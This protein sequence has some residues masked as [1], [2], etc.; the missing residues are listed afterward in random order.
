MRKSKRGSQECHTLQDDAYESPDSAYNSMCSSIMS[1][2]SAGSALDTTSTVDGV[3]IFYSWESYHRSDKS[4][5][6]L[7]FL[8][9][10]LRDQP[11]RRNDAELVLQQYFGYNDVSLRTNTETTKALSIEDLSAPTVTA[12]DDFVT[13]ELIAD[14]EPIQKPTVDTV[15][16]AITPLEESASSV[17]VD[18]DGPVKAALSLSSDVRNVQLYADVN[19]WQPVSMTLESGKRTWSVHVSRE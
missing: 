12:I 15:D 11:G 8:Y 2:V 4:K 6:G 1:T 5:S 18:N 10:Y 9:I 13:T 19:D 3:S 16:T 7:L 14:K 17:D